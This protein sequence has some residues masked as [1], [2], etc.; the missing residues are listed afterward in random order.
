MFFHPMDILI[1]IAFGISIWAQFRVKGTF[2]KWAEVP[3]GTGV[4]GA[5][6]A[7]ALLDKNGLEHIPIQGGSRYT[8]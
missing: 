3:S 8:F 2:K 7:R 6:V 4:S 5:E 1:L